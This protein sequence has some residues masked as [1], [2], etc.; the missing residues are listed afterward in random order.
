MSSVRPPRKPTTSAGIG[1][2]PRPA[3]SS[4]TSPTSAS[5]PVASTMRP[6]RSLTR[7][8][9]RCRSDRATTSPSAPRR[10]ATGE[11]I[12]EDLARALELGLQGG[13]DL[14]LDGADDRAAAGDAPLGLDLEVLHA[15][16]L[17]HDDAQPLADRLEVLGVD[18][19]GEALALQ[20]QAQRPTHGLDDELG[21]GGDG[22][23]DDLLG[24][25]QAQLD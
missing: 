19:D 17:G 11:L 5:R 20:Q 7:P 2:R 9:R 4:Q 13:V 1:A 6:M 22:R 12:F 3:R 14:A 18:E 8:R 24:D 21:I 23:A 10:S 15:A 16:E 25:A